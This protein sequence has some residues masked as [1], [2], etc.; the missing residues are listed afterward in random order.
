[1]ARRGTSSAWSCGDLVA[2]IE[3][4][5][6]AELPDAVVAAA[7]EG[8]VGRSE[9]ERRRRSRGDG[10][11]VAAASPARKQ[12]HVVCSAA[13]EECKRQPYQSERRK[14]SSHTHCSQDGQSRAFRPTV[15]PMGHSSRA[16]FAHVNGF[17]G[18]ERGGSVAERA[19]GL[20]RA[21]P[22]KP[23]A[24][25]RSNNPS[26]PNGSR[27]LFFESDGGPHSSRAR[28]LR[29][30]GGLDGHARVGPQ[31]ARRAASFASQ[32]RAAVAAQ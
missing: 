3:I 28:K 9:R 21:H 10:L 29:P 16:N 31:Q 17:V 23:T 11:V 14:L 12:A 26:R 22:L 5:R 8:W 7:V 13:Q 25:R 24:A 2:G 19:L 18:S 27:S 1:M 20:V 30:G 15:V 32:L 6:P 4:S